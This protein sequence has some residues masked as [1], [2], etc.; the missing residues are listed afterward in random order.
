MYVLLL[1]P[2]WPGKGFGNRSQ[3]RWPFKHRIRKT[4]VYPLDM[5]YTAA[6]LKRSGHRTAYLDSEYEGHDDDAALKHIGDDRPDIVLIETSAPTEDIDVKF[7]SL[8]KARFPD[9]AVVVGGN[10]ATSDPTRYL[11]RSEADIIII[12]EM[13]EAAAEIADALQ[14]S[15]DHDDSD[16]GSY[17][18]DNNSDNH[19]H[20]R[21]RKNR[22]GK[23]ED[24][25]L[26]RL[27]C[28][29]GIAFRCGNRGITIT[30]KRKLCD[31][32]RLPYPDRTTVPIGR[33]GS[34]YAKDRLVGRI[35]G[36]RGCTKRCMIC[37]FNDGFWQGVTRDR[38]V[39]S[40][41]D[42]MKALHVSS[43]I[44]EFI[45]EDPVFNHDIGRVKE[46]CRRIIDAGI[47]ASW[48]CTIEY[49]LYDEEMLRLMKEAG[50]RM[51]FFGLAS[52]DDTS[53]KRF[54][55][56]THISKD[57]VIR[58]IG[59]FRKAGFTT[60]LIAIAGLPWE[61]EESIFGNIEEM[62]SQRSV[63]HLDLFHCNAH[64]DSPLYRIAEKEGWFIR[65]EKPGAGRAENLSRSFTEPIF[66]SDAE[67][68]KLNRKIRKAMMKSRLRRSIPKC[69]RKAV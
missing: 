61:T 46:L 16:N 39:R 40:I 62:A 30:G 19:N 29:D 31:L 4:N 27:G 28:I 6:C 13:E 15:A 20:S 26:S 63:D 36:S 2:P 8:L 55:A 43:G 21:R 47:G 60:H 35:Q 41:V 68:K 44:R 58:T 67:P 24:H 37:T 25:I 42:E 45:F 64:P 49:G 3:F 66:E 33:Y 51:V 14:P 59:D 48:S 9:I 38:P 22:G 65:G 34:K 52:L 69:M 1:N 5:A 50:C 53:L 7:I 12:G 11:K 54:Y 32:R 57:I 18:D 17:D 56:G 23:R 10:V